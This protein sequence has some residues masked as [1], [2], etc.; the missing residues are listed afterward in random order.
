MTAVELGSRRAIIRRTF[1]VLT[2][3]R[4]ASVART[5]QESNSQSVGVAK[6]DDDH[7]P[8]KSSNRDPF[9]VARAL[10]LTDR[11]SR[12]RL[13]SSPLNMGKAELTEVTSRPVD[14]E[15]RFVTT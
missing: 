12:L 4:A 9:D 15:V 1:R 6:T 14:I 13:Y 3:Y 8:G 10:C 11:S 5:D 2:R 7:C